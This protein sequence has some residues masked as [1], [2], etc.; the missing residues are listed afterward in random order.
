VS[1]AE[2]VATPNKVPCKREN[3]GEQPFFRWCNRFGKENLADSR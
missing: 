1:E 2:S 3:V